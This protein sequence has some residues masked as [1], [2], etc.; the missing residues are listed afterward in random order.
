MRMYIFISMRAILTRKIWFVL[1]FLAA[2]VP[3]AAQD[4][5]VSAEE[6]ATVTGKA[7]IIIIP[8]ITGSE[9]VNKNT[10]EMVWFNTRRSKTNDLRLPISPN[11]AQNHDDLVAKDIIRGVRIIRFL[12]EV[13]I[14]E[15]LIDSLQ[16]R[17]GYTEATWDE[18]GANGHQDTFYVFPYDWRLDNVETARLLIRKIEALK[19]KLGK[20][21]LKFNVIA[22]SMGGLITRYAAMYGDRDLSAGDPKPNWAGTRHFE[23]IFLLGTPN[24]GSILALNAF[25]NGYSYAPINLPWVRD[26]NIY[27][28]F[29]IPSLYQLLPHEGSLRAYDEDLQPMEIDLFNPATWE[30]YEW[31]IWTRKGFAKQFSTDEQRTARLYFRNVLD[32][33]KKFQAALNARPL[34]T[35]PV[36]FHLVGSDCKPTNNAVLLRQDKKREKWITQFKPSAYTTADGKKISSE[37][38]TS[39][40]LGMGDGVVTRR[41]LA[42]QSLAKPG[43]AATLLI[44]SELS[45]CESHGRLVSNADIQDKL[46]NM[47]TQTQIGQQ[48]PAGTRQ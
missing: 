32:R 42:R 18:P 11:I 7:P 2:I 1:L 13:E 20:P 48:I 26:I 16:K 23:K 41:S 28:V 29:T 24:E 19:K 8:G 35:A 10:G 36:S 3:V 21:D 45:M 15:R 33:A 44:D 14:Y 22:H 43:E 17:G 12:P 27:D 40:L 5:P 37:E 30:E 47:L 4:V 38:L 46:F 6:T 25:I 34:D 9:L 39:L 31:A